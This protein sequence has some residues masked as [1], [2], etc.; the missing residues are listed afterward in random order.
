MSE[1][2]PIKILFISA[3]PKD[4]LRLQV[5]FDNIR[6]KIKD[7]LDKKELELLNPSFDTDFE[8]LHKRLKD[9]RPKVLHFSCHSTPEGI[10]LIN[11]RNRNTQMIEN[12]ELFDIFEDKISFLSLIF[13]NSCFSS[14]QA[15][16]ISK[17]G[18]FVLGLKEE[19]DNVLAKDLAECFYFG[20]DMYNK[21]NELDKAIR[22]GCTNFVKTFP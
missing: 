20:F 19:I 13:L 4:Q 10:C 9:E 1:Q 7:S 5:E 18:L 16:T 11:N 22:T 21:S 12:E 15:E 2:K 3:Q 17:A 8:K 14:F 6:N